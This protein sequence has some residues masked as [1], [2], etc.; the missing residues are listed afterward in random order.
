MRFEPQLLLASY[1]RRVGTSQYLSM[2]VSYL[3]IIK[4]GI[5]IITYRREPAWP[6]LWPDQQQQQGKPRDLSR[7]SNHDFPDADEGGSIL[8]KIQRIEFKERF[9][10]VWEK[11]KSLLSFF[12]LIG[13]SLLFKVG[14]LVKAIL[15]LRFYSP[16]LI[17]ALF[18][19]NLASAVL[20]YPRLAKKVDIKVAKIG[21]EMF[22]NI[23]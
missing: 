6:Q 13:S 18:L 11:V 23:E 1:S 7:K 4:T 12:P 16:I 17:L 2:V 21:K 20:L 8:Q 15:H 5:E 14:M 22:I 19:T 3:V 10:Q 9:K